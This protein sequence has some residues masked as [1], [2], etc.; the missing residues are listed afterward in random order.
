[1]ANADEPLMRE[2]SVL[3]QEAVEERVRVEGDEEQE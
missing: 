3:E 1:M 2:P